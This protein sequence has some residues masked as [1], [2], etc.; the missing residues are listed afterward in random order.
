VRTCMCMCENVF[1]CV[2]MCVCVHAD[3]HCD[4]FGVGAR[5]ELDL[6]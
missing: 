1:T 5:D 4:H 2:C 3:Q 6:L